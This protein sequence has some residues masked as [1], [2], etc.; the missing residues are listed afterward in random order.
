MIKVLSSRRTLHLRCVVRD[1]IQL[2]SAF[3][4]AQRCT[5][6]HSAWLSVVR[7]SIQYGSAL[8]GTALSLAHRCMGQNS[9]L[10]SVVR[11][12]YGT[13][14]W[15]CLVLSETTLNCTVSLIPLKT[16]HMNSTCEQCNVFHI[17][18]SKGPVRGNGEIKRRIKRMSNS[19][20]L[21]SI[22]DQTC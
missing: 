22:P 8:Y 1:S 7:D 10:L 14:A 5:G 17:L 3:S 21:C 20:L 11:E 6:Q 15:L 19:R 12:L 4:L 13:S 16:L 18:K 9:A 2:G